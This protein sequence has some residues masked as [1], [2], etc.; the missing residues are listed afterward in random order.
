M[1]VQSIQRVFRFKTDHSEPKLYHKIKR[2]TRGAFDMADG[3]GLSH[4]NK[5]T[6]NV[7]GSPIYGGMIHYYV[8]AGSHEGGE[9]QAFEHDAYT[10][11]R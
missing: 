10:F 6:L 7:L 11:Q 3:V 9:R 8:G 5:Q 2:L 1:Y 4:S